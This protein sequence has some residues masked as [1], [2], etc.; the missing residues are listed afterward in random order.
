[1][2]HVLT[3]RKIFLIFGFISVTFACATSKSHQSTNIS[4]KAETVPEGISLTFDYIPPET[5][6]MFI[7]I[8]KGL[9]KSPPAN[10]H[11]A[12][13]NSS[14]IRGE[15]LEQVKRARRIVFPIVQSGE[16]YAISVHFAKE[17]YQPI[18]GIP[19]WIN[20]ECIAGNGIYFDSNI[21]L[22]LDDT[23]TTVTLSSEPVF[24][25]EVVF[26]T[27]KYSYNITIIEKYTETEIIS[28]GGCFGDHT[29]NAL[30]CVFEP[31]WTN[32]LNEEN[33]LVSGSYPAYVTAFCNIIYDNIKWFVEVAKTPEFVYRYN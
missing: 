11:N 23:Q 18:E 1:M 20:T 26:D 27:Y 29:T 22:K 33:Y 10:P 24:S 6:Y 13:F 8:K 19:E 5:T 25:S 16:A 30:K 12:V 31:E 9:E 4:L 7:G 17:G 2:Q 15:S 32:H 28:S 3:L 14:G 21:K